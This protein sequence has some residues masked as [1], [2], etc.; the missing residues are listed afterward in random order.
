M[1][2]IRP[3]VPATPDSINH[4]P[5]PNMSFQNDIKAARTAAGLTQ[6]AAAPSNTLTQ[7]MK[8]NHTSTALPNSNGTPVPSLLFSSQQ[9][10]GDRAKA[11][12]LA[13]KAVRDLGPS[14]CKQINAHGAQIYS[15]D[16]FSA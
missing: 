11:H 10:A 7:P 3:T 2:A 13:N 9:F 12:R 6:A 1:S 8:N 15:F 14:A 4:T 16:I 5:T